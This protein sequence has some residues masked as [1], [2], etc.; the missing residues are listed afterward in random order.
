MITI[1]DYKA[2]N[3]TSVKRALEAL[4]CPVEI[5]AD[6]DRLRRAERVI[7]PGV[8]AA[9]QAM[10]ELNRS[11]L[12]QALKEVVQQGRPVLG[13][14]IGCQII[15]DESEENQTTCLGLIPGQT[16]AFP[17]P[18]LDHSGRRL[19]VP[20]MG[21]NGVRL[22][23]DHPLWAK[24]PAEAE[25]YFVHGYYPRPESEELVLG[26]T[27]YGFE[28]PSIIG[29]DNLLAVQFHVEKSGRPGLA[30]LANFAAW[31]P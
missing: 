27:D 18:L 29:R 31:R 8:G 28:F 3:L 6:P 24:V 12:G 1:V 5:S 26:L 10:G 21:W 25:F 14:C 13:I 22:V 15:L 20:H 11:G 30:L 19:K 2:G 7:F 4:D 23:R 9:G 17:Q 16:K